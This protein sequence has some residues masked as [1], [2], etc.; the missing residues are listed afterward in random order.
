M[1]FFSKLTDNDHRPFFSHVFRLGGGTAIGQLVVILSMPIITRIYTP[2]E[3]GILSLLVAFISFVGV[4]TGLRYELAIVSSHDDQEAAIL[5]W[6]SFLTSIPIAVLCSLFLLSM[7]HFNILSYGGLPLWSIPIIGVLLICTQL[8]MSL[9]YWYV[10]QLNFSIIA[11]S[12]I[13]QGFGR[14]FVP[15]LAGLTGVGWVGLLMGEVAGRV[16]GIYRMLISALPS[17]ASAIRGS[18]WRDIS[19]TLRK[20]L[21]YP[22]I[23]LPSSLLD[24]L[25]STLPLPVV[26]YLFGTEKAG[27]FFLV[28]RFATLP[29]AF[30]SASIADVFH[31]RVSEDYRTNPDLVR[32]FLIRTAGKMSKIGLLI[33]IPLAIISPFLFGIIF[34][35]K[36]ATAGIVMSITAPLAL[37]SLVVSPVS[38][39]L[40]VV[41]RTEI[42]LLADFI[43]LVLPLLGIT[44]SHHY[45][46]NFLFSMTVFSFMHIIANIFYFFIIWISSN[47]VKVQT[48]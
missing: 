21:K 4:G 43:C 11:K 6:A 1:S 37:F 12:M 14:A 13:S 10:R 20:Y 27:L 8:F 31:A 19:S 16:F 7:I 35:E 48:A 45:N 40:L 22:C 47:P 29:A 23:V 25:A 2:V 17:L 5:T 24:A 18:S 26:S 42:K 36:W 46:G 30:I 32:P 9:R 38:R 3:M 33:Y 34:G 28:M 15:L 44:I 39:L 41:N